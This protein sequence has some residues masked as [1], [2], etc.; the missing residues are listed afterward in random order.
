M[1]APAA[2]P[3]QGERRA[4][5][6]P[7]AAELERVACPEGW[8]SPAGYRGYLRQTQRKMRERARRRG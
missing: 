2:R 5:I 1:M 6:P 3:A 7:G 8:M 4:S